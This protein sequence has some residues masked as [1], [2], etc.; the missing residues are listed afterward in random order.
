MIYPVS[1]G[2]LALST[3]PVQGR[4]E[5][6]SPEAGISRLCLNS[7]QGILAARSNAEANL[8]TIISLCLG[9]ATLAGRQGCV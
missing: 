2:P 4:L 8:E 7:G 6:F 9:W 5:V 3:Y 1:P